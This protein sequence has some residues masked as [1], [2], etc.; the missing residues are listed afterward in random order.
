MLQD[1]FMFSEILSDDAEGG[2]KKQAEFI[3]K[4]LNF[5]RRILEWGD[6]DIR[7]LSVLPSINKFN[8]S[9]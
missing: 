9:P 8:A 5:L 2:E 6:G 4:S 7:G 1:M 3:S